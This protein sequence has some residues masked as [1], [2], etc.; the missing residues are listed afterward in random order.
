MC[1]NATN[2]VFGSALP[3]IPHWPAADTLLSV[4]SKIGFD[5]AHCRA[6]IALMRMNANQIIRNSMKPCR[7]REIWVSP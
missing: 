7:K 3:S 5:I 1:R 4:R 6:Y 2:A